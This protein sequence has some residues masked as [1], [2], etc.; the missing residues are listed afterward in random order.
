VGVALAFSHML[1]NIVGATIWYPLRRV[2]IEM[3]R[4]WARVASASKRYAIIHIL[5]FF[6]A[7][8]TLVI[9]IEWLRR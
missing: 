6:F 3:A 4:W 2:P 8:P 9:L 1:F 5:A 7:L